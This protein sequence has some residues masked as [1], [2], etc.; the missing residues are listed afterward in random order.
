LAVNLQETPATAKEFV[1]TFGLTFPVL[2]ATSSEVPLAYN[3]RGIPATFF[4]DENGIIQDIK[5]GAFTS[6][7]EIASRLSRIIP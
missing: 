6:E 7:V 1:E 2:L 3:L 5:I 4:I